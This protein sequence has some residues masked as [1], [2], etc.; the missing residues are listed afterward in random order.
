MIYPKVHELKI[1]LR[2]GNK[3]SEIIQLLS[4]GLTTQKIAERLFASQL[5]VEVHRR[6][7]ISKLK[8][9]MQ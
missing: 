5:T 3:K 8:L 6:N 1:L 4:K 7:L 2:V 9:K